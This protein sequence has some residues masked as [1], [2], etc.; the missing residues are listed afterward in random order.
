MHQTEA[1]NHL[2]LVT[3]SS[4]KAP[5]FKVFK[6]HHGYVIKCCKDG[7]TVNSVVNVI[8]EQVQIT[9]GII[10]ILFTS[11]TLSNA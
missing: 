10:C 4:K 6:F 11:N 8:S 1:E 7:L 3:M 5:Y 2:S 9:A